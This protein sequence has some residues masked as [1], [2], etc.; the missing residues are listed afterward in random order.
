MVPTY[1]NNS[2]IFLIVVY[3][4]AVCFSSIN[5]FTDVLNLLPFDK[6]CIILS[7]PPSGRGTD[8]NGDIVIWLALTVLGIN[9]PSR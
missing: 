6:L 5:E 9:G 2:T 3:D 1:E 8:C 7:F 4:I